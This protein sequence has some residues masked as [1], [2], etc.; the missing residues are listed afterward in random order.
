MKIMESYDFEK[1]LGRKLQNDERKILIEKL[2]DN[3]LLKKGRGTYIS[4]LYS[5]LREGKLGEQEAYGAILNYAIGNGSYSYA[6]Q[7]KMKYTP[8]TIRE[9]VKIDITEE[10]I[11]KCIEK[12]NKKVKRKNMKD[13]VAEQKND[14]DIGNHESELS[15]EETFRQAEQTKESDNQER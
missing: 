14:V 2:L 5:K 3:S 6:I 11:R 1:I 7:G 13:I 10:D 8:E 9:D 12:A 4:M 15:F